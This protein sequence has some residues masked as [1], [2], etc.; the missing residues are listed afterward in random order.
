MDLLVKSDTF[1]ILLMDS[2]D[3]FP[4]CGLLLTLSL[5]FYE[6]FARI[7]R[8]LGRM[9]WVYKHGKHSFQNTS[10][11]SQVPDEGGGRET[12]VDGLLHPLVDLSQKELLRDAAVCWEDDAVSEAVDVERKVKESLQKPKPAISLPACAGKTILLSSSHC[13]LLMKSFPRERNGYWKRMVT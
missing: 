13:L 6:L 4:V 11:F 2:T 9:Q 3:N 8:Q 10:Q 7:Y 1:P 5:S 12:F